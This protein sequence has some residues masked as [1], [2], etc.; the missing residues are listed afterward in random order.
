[1]LA[2]AQQQ[3]ISEYSV[4]PL[5]IKVCGMTT[6]EAVAAAVAARVNAIG[7]VFHP[8]SV[9]NLTPQ[10]AAELAAP[11][12]LH[13][14]KVAVTLRPTQELIDDIATHFPAD[15]LQVDL[16]YVS[17]MQLPEHFTLLPVVRSGRVG[18][19]LPSQRFLFEGA[20]SGVGQRADWYEAQTL[21]AR[22]ELILAGG[23]DIHVVQQAVE[24]VR[25][26]GV[27]VSSGIEIK[28]GIKDPSLIMRFVE[29]ARGAALSN[30]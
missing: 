12:P 29:A 21:A 17:Y 16:D 26:F 6:P 19:L 9:R 15:Q 13:I 23:L 24:F 7:F 3:C 4:M 14:K 8:E 18:D 10:R 28:A 1:M 25:P 22:G 2:A 27:D 20:H 11:I 30:E 5:W